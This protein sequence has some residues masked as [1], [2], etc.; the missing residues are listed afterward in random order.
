[1]VLWE[2]PTPVKLRKRALLVNQTLYGH[3]QA[4]GFLAFRQIHYQAFKPAYS[5]TDQTMEDFHGL[6]IMGRD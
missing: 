6:R 2:Y 1:M 3:L 4:V 5:T